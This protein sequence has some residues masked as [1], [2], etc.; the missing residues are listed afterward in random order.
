MCDKKEYILK[1]GSDL[2]KEEIKNL[3]FQGKNDPLWL[4]C[5]SFYYDK[6]GVLVAGMYPVTTSCKFLPY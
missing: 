5:H 4:E 1:K 2:T 3:P 6:N